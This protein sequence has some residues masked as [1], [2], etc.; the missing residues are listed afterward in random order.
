[1]ISDL[2]CIR[3]LQRLPCHSQAES[4]KLALCK[5]HPPPHWQCSWTP[6]LSAFAGAPLLSVCLAVHSTK[7]TKCSPNGL[8]QR[9]LV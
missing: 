7:S 1:M 9:C 6:S 4:L 8:D 5:A 2:C 3:R